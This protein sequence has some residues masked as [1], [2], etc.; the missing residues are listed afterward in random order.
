MLRLALD[1][2]STHLSCD[3]RYASR[4]EVN[5]TGCTRAAERLST[6]SCDVLQ[7]SDRRTYQDQACG[8]SVEVEV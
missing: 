3:D 2:Q 8:S 7:P 6:R 1:S 5:R 4:I